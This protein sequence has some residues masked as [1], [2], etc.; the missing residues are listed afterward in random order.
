MYFLHEYAIARGFVG[1]GIR[2]EK[3]LEAASV[4]AFLAGGYLAVN[5]VACNFIGAALLVAAA[6]ITGHSFSSPRFRGQGLLG[7]A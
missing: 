6:L 2:P 1:H 4:T 5:H 3:C 7:V